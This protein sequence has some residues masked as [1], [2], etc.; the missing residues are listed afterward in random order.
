MAN[1]AHIKSQKSKKVTL[2]PINYIV[3]SSGIGVDVSREA[4]IV[5]IAPTALKVLRVKDDT[6][7]ELNRS[8]RNENSGPRVRTG[9]VKSLESE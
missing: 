9:Y 4:K 6:I 8:L 7:L 3:G 1:K 2:V 5:R